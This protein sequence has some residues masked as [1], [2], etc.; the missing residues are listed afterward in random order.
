MET[1]SHSHN[2]TERVIIE[3]KF[4][5]LHEEKIFTSLD[6]PSVHVN[7][8]QEYALEFIYDAQK[9]MWGGKCMVPPVGKQIFICLSKISSKKS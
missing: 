5:G 8:P 7:V 1:W 4:A 2:L 3:I 6:A 9:I